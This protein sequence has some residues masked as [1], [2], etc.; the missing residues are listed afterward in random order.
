ME[1]MPR[2]IRYWKN[3]KLPE[4][5][6]VVETPKGEKVVVRK[7]I[8]GRRRKK[9]VGLAS[10]KI[11]DEAIAWVNARTED[12][13]QGRVGIEGDKV[14]WPIEKGADIFFRLHGSRRFK[15]DGTVNRQAVAGCRRDLDNMIRL[16][17]GKA[18]HQPTYID[19]E[20]Y[21]AARK[22]EGLK[23]SSINREHTRIT[24]MFNKLKYWRRIG[25]DDVP[26]NLVLPEDNPGEVCPKA[27]EE[28][29]KRD[30]LISKEQYELLYMVADNRIK[31]ILI[32]EM[33]APLRLE[34]LRQ[35][36]KTKINAKA[37]EFKGVQ[38]KTGNEYFIPINKHL[39]DLIRTSQ[40]D[41]IL[42]FRGFRKRWNKA[43][44]RAGLKGL[45]FHDLR[46]TAATT[47]HNN[48]IPLKVV[49]KM[50]GHADVQT[51][52]RYLGL[53]VENLHAAGKVL[54]SVYG[55]PQGESPFQM[56][57]ELVLEQKSQALK[58]Q[59]ISSKIKSISPG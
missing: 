48:G 17:S 16:W 42:D 30:T 33:N 46:R 41:L 23:D 57:P 34:D 12:K 21:R 8:G 14:V 55:V 32:A 29:F 56:V 38:A 58:T 53:H 44:A 10:P 9:D 2:E 37:N 25:H 52:E 27:S 20:E 4:G 45:H 18:L 35:L 13:R 11:I 6:Y 15:R 31:R 7:M 3:R 19:M 24:T 59:S 54:E 22:R 47:L 50:L 26:K 39:W 28:K 49:S 36:T 40:S 1:P 51:T 43:V 5:I